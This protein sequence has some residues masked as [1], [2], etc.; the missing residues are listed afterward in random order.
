MKVDHHQY[1]LRDD[2]DPDV[3]TLNDNNDPS[4]NPLVA[5]D[6]SGRMAGIYTGMYGFDLPMTVEAWTRP[7][8]PDLTAWEEAI[9]FSL[10]LGDGARI[11]SLLNTDGSLGFDLPAQA[12]PAPRT[13]QADSYRVRLHARG[14]R[15]AEEIQHI[16]IDEGDEPVEEHLIQ[17]WGA[18]QQP[19]QWLKELDWPSWEPDTSL[20]RTDFYV[21]TITGRYCLAD[22]T[23]E[24]YTA[25]VT[26]RGNALI[27]AE[28][29]GH[30]AAVFTAQ[31]H[32]VVEVM[33]D[34][35]P[36]EPQPEL[37]NWDDITDITMSFTGPYVECR[38]LGDQRS[39]YSYQDLPL[40]VGETRTFRVRVSAKGRRTRHE[41][42]DHTSGD[43][44]HAE[45]HMIQI[46]PAPPSPE[47]TWPISGR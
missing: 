17:I 13:A 2:T 14:R 44:R 35:L 31:P 23:T 40:E 47:K 25:N 21:E 16:S 30:I 41:L 12:V 19:L 11:E 18:P 39:P 20:P 7:P 3:D 34:V 37:S 36:H 27:A 28:P 15:R 33:L 46:W 24:R 8:E 6:D 29:A 4:T 9:E 45:R 5:I 26:A 42:A 32:S 38:F 43:Q 22:D 10:V 1:W